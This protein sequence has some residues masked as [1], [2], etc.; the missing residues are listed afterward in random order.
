MWMKVTSTASR[1]YANM[2]SFHWVDRD[3][4]NNLEIYELNLEDLN[5]TDFRSINHHLRDITYTACLSNSKETYATFEPLNTLGFICYN[6]C[7]C[8]KQ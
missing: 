3:Y 4:H 5:E 7:C 6:I 8:L 2:L 1:S